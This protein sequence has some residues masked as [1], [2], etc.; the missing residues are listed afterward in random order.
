MKNLFRL[1]FLSL[2][3]VVA[4]CVT[5]DDLDVTSDL[6]GTW[7]MTSFSS[8]NPYDLNGDGTANTDI[9]IE[10]GCYQNE[11][12]DFNANGTGVATNRSYLDIETII[13][14]GTTNEVEYILD[15]VDEFFAQDFTWT[16]NGSSL[17]LTIDG[18][19]IVAT[20][21]GNTITLIL[22][23]GFTVEV[24][25]SAGNNALVETTENV[26]VVYTKQ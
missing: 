26:T 14:V 18:I 15:C 7:R 25:D 3:L 2:F 13:T 5:N 20:L 4:S 10:T 22:P 11:T 19:T 1:T 9:I 24:I 12:L 23:S 17:S 21:S 8:E 6:E 16:Q